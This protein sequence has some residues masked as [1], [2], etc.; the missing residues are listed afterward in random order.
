MIR[1]ACVVALV[2]LTLSPASAQERG[3]L[4]VDEAS[5]RHAFSLRG[6]ADAVN[7]CGTAGCEVVATFSACLGVAYSS[8]TQGPSVWTWAEAGTE[9]LARRGAFDEC[10]RVGGPACEVLNVIC[11]DAPA[12][13]AALGLDRAAR[14]VIQRGLA[15]EGFDAGVADGL[16]GP[17]TRRALRGWQASRGAPATGY[18]DS[19]AAELL[20]TAGARR[21]P[22]AGVAAASAPNAGSAA[23]GSRIR[24]DQVCAGQPAGAACWMEI[25]QR[26]GCYVW[27]PGLQPGATV[28]WTGQCAGGFAQGAGTLTWVSEGNQQTNTGRLQNGRRT[29]H[30]VL[31]F[32]D[33]GVQEGPFVDGER[34]GRWVIRLA[35]GGVREGPFVD[36]ERTGHWVLSWADGEVQEGPFVDGEK[37]GRWILRFADGDVQ[38][39]PFV[40][41]ERNGHWVVFD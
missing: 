28:T 16:F 27:N 39:G 18:L 6:E 3:A 22:T 23:P 38:A 26:S 37:N 2:L 15:T 33:G 11:L 9:G 40:D 13:E 24:G 31:R 20:R 10:Q 32:A 1:V 25:A 19:G 5:A 12:S 21:L 41:G 7:M 36:G 4:A 8:P 17:R 29:G 14:R 35:D 34:N 30:W